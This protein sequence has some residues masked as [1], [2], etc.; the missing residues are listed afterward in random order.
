MIKRK[1]KKVEA[2][3]KAVAAKPQEEQKSVPEQTKVVQ[4]VEASRKAVA[5]K[6]QEEQKSIPEQTKVVQK[7][8]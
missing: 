6:P 4:K 7:V 2:S 1:V 5:A 3:R 8:Y